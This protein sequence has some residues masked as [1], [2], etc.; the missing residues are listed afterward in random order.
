MS[1]VE[2]NAHDS[3]YFPTADVAFLLL[4]LNFLSTLNACCVHTWKNYC[5]DIS[6]QT[7][8]AKEVF[9]ITLI[10]Y[11]RWSNIWDRVLFLIL[12]NFSCIFNF[13]VTIRID[14]GLNLLVCR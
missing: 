6:S 5:I 13:T 12:I 4:S 14:I 9:I 10:L 3:P 8:L 1:S 2:V 11:L 7:D